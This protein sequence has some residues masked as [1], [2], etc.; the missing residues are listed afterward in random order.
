MMAKV[1]STFK[2]ASDQEIIELY[3]SHISYEII[4]VDGSKE[5]ISFFFES[6]VLEKVMGKLGL[7]KKYHMEELLQQRDPDRVLVFYSKKQY[8]N[9]EFFQT[10]PTV[11][12]EQSISKTVLD[13]LEF[14]NKEM[15]KNSTMQQSDFPISFLEAFSIQFPS[16]LE[17]HKNSLTKQC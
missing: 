10:K 17:Q 1:K 12:G 13:A 7:N 2:F 4:K 3:Q 16:T 14:L 5:Y 15:K 9:T 8:L 6:K 11:E